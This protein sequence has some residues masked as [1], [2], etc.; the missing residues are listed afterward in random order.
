MYMF[1][2]PPGCFSSVYKQYYLFIYVQDSL[3]S[4]FQ[5]FCRYQVPPVCFICLVKVGVPYICVV[6]PAPTQFQWFLYI[7]WYSR[8]LGSLLSPFIFTLLG[9]LDFYGI[10][11]KLLGICIKL[12]GNSFSSLKLCGN[13]GVFCCDTDFG[14][15]LSVIPG[16]LGYCINWA[17]LRLFSLARNINFANKVYF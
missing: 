6:E 1:A 13:D 7:T 9:L 3:D 14:C 2:K 10:W 12:G 8:N 5:Y 4:Q 15:R 11:V 16:D 17:R